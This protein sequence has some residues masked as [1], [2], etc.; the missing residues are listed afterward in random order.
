MLYPELY[1]N[2]HQLQAAGK[3]TAE[4][5]ALVTTADPDECRRLQTEFSEYFTT[6]PNQQVPFSMLQL[7]CAAN[8]QKAFA[9]LFAWFGL[10]TIPFASRPT[11]AGLPQTHCLYPCYR[12]VKKPYNGI[13]GMKKEFVQRKFGPYKEF[14]ILEEHDDPIKGLVINAI[15]ATCV[16]WHD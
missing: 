9:E 11:R 4:Y 7:R 1:L 3:H 6:E 12:R 2:C 8:P 16:A 5:V 15:P 13:T 14:L 10:L